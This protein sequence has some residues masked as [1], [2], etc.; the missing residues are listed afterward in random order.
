MSVARE[1]G[2]PIIPA[3]LAWARVRQEDPD[4]VLYHEDGSHPAPAGSYLTASTLYAT[5][6]GS[7][8]VGLSSTLTGH[9]MPEGVLNP[10]RTVTL[11]SLGPEQAER[12]QRVAWTT[13][14]QLRQSGGYVEVQPPSPELPTL[15]EGQ[16]LEPTTL[17]GSWQG[18]MRFYSQEAG[19]SPAMLHL[20]LKQAG[21]HL[22]GTVRIVFAN[23]QTE[24]PFSLEALSMEAS[25]LR[26]STPL[27]SK[28]RGKVEHEAVLTAEGLVGLAR[29][30]NPRNHDRYV[31]TWKLHR[32]ELSSG[33]AVAPTTPREPPAAQSTA[34]P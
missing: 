5:L 31:G 14:E 19:Q 1:L 29:Y 24:G 23:G 22:G 28:G 27:L 15:P 21:A 7:S 20:A 33:A 34:A 9:P 26:F 12:L 3:G 2:A 6:T 17:L 13:Y 10:A 4:V 11:A 32:P 16:P 18:E 8:P 25:R 30:E